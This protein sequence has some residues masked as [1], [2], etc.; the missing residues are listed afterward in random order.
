MNVP[1]LRFKEFSG[2]WEVKKLGDIFTFKNGVNA[3][4]EQYG[5]GYKFINVLDIINN[6]FIT[7][8]KII[9][10]VN[11]SED[12]FIKNEVKFGDVLFQRSSETREEVGQSNVYIGHQSV[13]FGGF[14]IRGRGITK[15]SPSFFNYVLKTSSIR[16]EITQRSGGSTRYNVG[17]NSLS[18]V[19]AFLP[20][21]PEQIKIANFLTAVDEKITQLTQKCDL[22]AQYKKGV[23]QKIFSQELRFKDDDGKEFP[24]WDVID[25][26]QIAF[27]VN[28]KNRNLEIS[29]VLTNSATQGIISQNDYFDRDIAN[30]NN[31]DG[32]YVVERNDFVYNPRISNNAPVGPIKRNKLIRGVMSPLYTVFRFKKGELTFF[33]Y[34]F[35]TTC[36]H[37]Y[38]KSISNSGARH[39]R[40]NITNES[41]FALPIELPSVKEQ[42]KIADFLTAI[43]DKITQAQ[44]QLAA[45]KQYKRGL[46]QQMF[47]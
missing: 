15:Y 23:M 10:S 35:E 21:I 8:E 13:T 44:A 14:V 39:D 31:L 4:K 42:T 24:E 7:Y 45:V 9:G 11:I 30:K 22:L 29:N 19:P 5:S 32:Y 41:F 26:E 12:E 34:F 28:L 37:D 2:E 36:W 40:M 46:L 33:E 16:D 43:D 25:L 20:R 3:S 6:N 1:Q 27:K 47:V 18:A 38:M 17:Q